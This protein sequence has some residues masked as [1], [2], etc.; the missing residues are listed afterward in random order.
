MTKSARKQEKL[1]PVYLITGSD[2]PKIEKAVRRLKD[3]VI[4]ESGTDL[5]VDVFDAAEH[6]A[7]AVVQAAGTPPFGTGVRLV[8][9][10][11]VGDWHKADK[12]VIAAFLADPVDYSCLA[13]VG[14][15]IRK[16]E[17]IYKAVIEVGQ[18]LVYEAPRF[19]GLPVWA[20]EQAA[21]RHLKLGAREAQ[22][23]VGLTGS[24]QRAI[25]SE[26]DKLSAYVGKRAV[27]SE[28]IDEL[29][30]VSRE[31]K[32]WDMTDAL[33]Q[34]DREAVFRHLEELL[35]GH[36]APASVFFSIARHLKNL[37]EVVS[38]GERGEDLTRAAHALGLKPFPARKIAEQ[39]RNFTADGLRRAV[40]ILAELDADMK[41]RKDQRP[42]LTL[43]I[44]VARVLDIV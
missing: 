32:V 6:S 16:N 17:A 1:K 44:A 19:A 34:R 13:L 35:A 26:L 4:S 39:S 38:A 30:W 7:H 8:L 3:R 12:D 15:G 9:V 18:V 37:C 5:N 23:L 28:D 25:V 22:H 41:G 2:D 10:N 36:A 42:D 27:E 33:G 40:M 20:Q 31:T 29:C 24:D 14:G 21:Q 11:S 43:E